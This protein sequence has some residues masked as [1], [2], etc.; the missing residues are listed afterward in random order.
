MDELHLKISWSD[1]EAECFQKTQL[2]GRLPAVI[3]L[4]RRFVP[5]YHGDRKISAKLSLSF[6]S[7]TCI[8]RTS[9]TPPSLGSTLQQC[10][11][12]CVFTEA[13]RRSLRACYYFMVLIPQVTIESARNNCDDNNHNS[14]NTNSPLLQHQVQVLCWDPT[15]HRVLERGCPLV[16]AGWERSGVRTEWESWWDTHTL[17]MPLPNG[18]NQNCEL[19]N[20]SG[21]NRVSVCPC[22]CLWVSVWVVKWNEVFYLCKSKKP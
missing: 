8:G 17:H 9:H 2:S 12:G 18:T 21:N 7:I 11:C 13:R 1:P 20:N 4:N 16:M 15:R 14:N 22:V 6:S 5:R 3:L 19:S 10:L